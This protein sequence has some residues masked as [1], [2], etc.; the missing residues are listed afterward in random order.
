MNEETKIAL[1]QKDLENIKKSQ[2]R[3]ELKVDALQG[4]FWTTKGHEEFVA[5][6]NKRFASLENN[7]GSR[8]YLVPTISSVLTALM[9]F[10]I[11]NYLQHLR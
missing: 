4:I 6:V 8:Q 11:I 9:T 2:D 10:L 3:M 1:I 7:A 5:E